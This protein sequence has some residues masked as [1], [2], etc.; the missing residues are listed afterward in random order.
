MRVFLLVFTDLSEAFLKVWYWLG[1]EMKFIV[2]TTR[3]TC[4]MAAGNSTP[5]RSDLKSVEHTL[6]KSEPL[7]ST[8]ISTSVED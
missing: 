2:C 5:I 4:S 1:Y 3:H 7:V 8:H 6:P